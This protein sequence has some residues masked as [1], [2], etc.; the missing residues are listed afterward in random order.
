MDA[1]RACALIRL[2]VAPKASV[3][4]LP[5]LAGTA[6]GARTSA[7]LGRQPARRTELLWAS[8]RTSNRVG[9]PTA[10]YNLGSEEMSHVDPDQL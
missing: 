10:W 9:M 8:K 7:L 5:Y 4:T 1:T 2:S 3:D 6:P